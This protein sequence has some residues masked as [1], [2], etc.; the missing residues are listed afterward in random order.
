MEVFGLNYSQI[1]QVDEHTVILP[2]PPKDKSEILFI[3]KSAKNAYW[4]RDTNFPDYFFHFLPY[5]TEL[6]ADA[7]LYDEN[8]ILLSLNIEDSEKFITLFKREINRRKNGVFFRNGD[9]LEYLTGHHYHLLQ[10]AKIKGQDFDYAKFRKYQR[11]FFYLIEHCWQD[12]NILGS[13][14]SKPKKTGITQ[15]MASGYFL[16]YSTLNRGKL[17]GVMNFKLEKA[18]QNNMGVYFYSFDN[19]PECFKPIIKS[20]TNGSIEFDIPVNRSRNPAKPFN[21]ADA[22][23]TKVYAS[24]TK[25]AAF[26]SDKPHVIWLDELP[27]YDK[28]SGI[29]PAIC[30]DK[31]SA[32]VQEPGKYTGRIFITSYPPEENT[33]GFFQCRDLYSNS[34]LKTKSKI[35]QRTT[36]G[37]ICFHISSV[38]SYPDNF[39]EYG[40]CD[41]R[42]SY[43]QNEA[44]R[45]Q[46]RQSNNKQKLQSLIRQAARNEREAWYM[47]TQGSIFDPLRLAILE[48]DLDEKLRSGKYFKQGELQWVVPLWEAGR[49]DKRPKGVFDRVKFVETSEHDLQNGK[50][51][52]YREYYE[53]LNIWK[54]LPLTTGR[55]DYNNVLPPKKFNMVGAV[56]PT[57]FRDT[58][59]AT[60]G[61]TNSMHAMAVHDE[62][63]NT[64]NRSV[65]TKIFNCEY[66]YRP[67]NPEEFYQDVVKFII[68]TGALVIVEAN[69]GWLAER[70]EDEGLGHYMLFKNSDGI[71]CKY[72]ANHKQTKNPLKHIRTLKSG[73]VDTVADFILYI[74]NYI[75]EADKNLGEIDYGEMI[76]SERLIKQLMD[77]DP[78]D[79]KRFDLVITMGYTLMAHENY[80]ILMHDKSDKMYEASAISQ[81]YQA[82]ATQF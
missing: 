35:L 22:L 28:E 75:Q 33:P 66:F 74:K 55:D 59:N 67:D 19:M 32:A 23:G 5:R 9:D 2:E 52:R 27:K 79:T 7:T 8:G 65:V 72:K 42:K 78:D 14:C 37:M 63:M 18:I 10:W 51:G 49:K 40:N 53:V 46:A 61:S 70:L 36:T 64:Y 54:N 13:Y 82:F 48:Q 57:D 34:K 25:E 47:G 29:Q 6:Y 4:Q 30:F 60:E 69:N 1:I 80:L 31:N 81:I 43:E 68:Y 12:P 39:D 76:H 56:D 73:G 62:T 41:T 3:N 58:G 44:E 11:D 15:I 38:N 21:G 50:T 17:L 45:D 77:F 71:L 24:S 26:D 20:R 16:N